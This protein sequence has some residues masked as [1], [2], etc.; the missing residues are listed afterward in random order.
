MQMALR[1]QWFGWLVSLQIYIYRSAA[2]VCSGGSLR[3]RDE[4]SLYVCL[5]GS[6]TLRRTTNATRGA[7]QNKGASRWFDKTAQTTRKT[8]SI[9]NT[10]LQRNREASER[11]RRERRFSYVTKQNTA[12]RTNNNVG[13]RVCVCVYLYVFVVVYFRRGTPGVRDSDKSSISEKVS[14]SSSDSKSSS[15]SLSCSNTA[16]NGFM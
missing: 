13:T 14:V 11:L 15:S 1:M 8:M 4:S 2:S 5:V 9:N 3:K 6:T 16:S 7:I 10:K 12:T